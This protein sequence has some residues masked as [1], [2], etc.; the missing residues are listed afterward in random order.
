MTTKQILVA[1]RDLITNPTKWTKGELARDEDGYV[2]H[3]EDPAAVCFC[4]YGAI[5]HCAGP[6]YSYHGTIAKGALIASANALYRSTP[7][8][9]NDDLGHGAALKMFDHAILRTDMEKPTYEELGYL[10]QACAQDMIKHHVSFGASF[11]CGGRN[12][13]CEYLHDECNLTLPRAKEI[14][15]TEFEQL[16]AWLE[17]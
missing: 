4:A 5:E 15:L 14:A 3:T 10:L 8:S 1:A 2:V 7:I 9:V 12:L 16:I 11:E 17:D 6:K 13:V